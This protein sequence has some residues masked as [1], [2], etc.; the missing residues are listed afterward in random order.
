M[1]PNDRI[2]E[3]FGYGDRHDLPIR[4]W[5]PEPDEADLERMAQEY[6]GNG[7]DEEPLPF[8]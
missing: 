3:Q 1:T 7:L 8:E 2:R 5:E 4:Y 6:R